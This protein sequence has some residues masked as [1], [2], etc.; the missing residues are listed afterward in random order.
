MYKLGQ[1]QFGVIK[2]HSMSSAITPFDRARM[3][4]C[5]FAVDLLQLYNKYTTQSL[6]HKTCTI[7]Q[8]TGKLC[9]SAGCTCMYYTADLYYRRDRHCT[10]EYV[11]HSLGLTVA[12]LGPRTWVRRCFWVFTVILLK[13]V[14]LLQHLVFMVPQTTRTNVANLV[15]VRF[16]LPV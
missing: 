4:C 1:V 7:T 2:G 12:M 6:G 15:T 13:V 10:V 16:L 8:C 11:T 5:G 3:T 9:A 14:S